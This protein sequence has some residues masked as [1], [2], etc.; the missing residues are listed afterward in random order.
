MGPLA[1]RLLLESLLAPFLFA[2]L[3]TLI[4]KDLIAP[5]MH[6]PRAIRDGQPADVLRLTIGAALFVPVGIWVLSI[7][8]P[9]VFR[10]SVSL[11]ALGLLA[12]LILGLR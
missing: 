5:L 9:D 6:V 8:H 12:I 2:A 7:V 4:V 1:A 11:V 10:W 3:T